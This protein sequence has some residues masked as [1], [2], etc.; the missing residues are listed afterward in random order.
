MKRN[1]VLIA[2]AIVGIL[3]S[4]A[5]TTTATS[6][7][8]LGDIDYYNT[9]NNFIVNETIPGNVAL[10][11]VYSEMKESS[12]TDEKIWYNDNVTTYRFTTN[13]TYVEWWF[14][15]GIKYFV[16][17]DIIT[18]KLYSVGVNYTDIDIPE[19]PYTERQ[20]Q[21][22]ENYTLI[23][24]NYNLT[25]AT[26]TNITT[27][28][29]ELNDTYGV[30]MQ[31]L[32]ITLTEKQNLSENLTDVRTA[33]TK[34]DNDYN[35]TYALWESAVDNVTHFQTEYEGKAFDYKELKKD[36]DDLSGAAPWYVIIAIIGTFLATWIY[37][38][39]K[40]IF[41]TT[42]EST[43]EI[44]T[45]Y[46]KVHSAIDKH[47]LSRLKGDAKTGNEGGIEEITDLKDGPAKGIPQNETKN[48]PIEKTAQDD[49]LEI[50]HKKIDENTRALTKQFTDG[51]K[52]IN[53]KIDKIISEKATN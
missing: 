39:R 28:F 9:Q 33:F 5:V 40:N 50:V 32:N 25:N 1:Y 38:R 13:K 45:G 6:I 37:I 19:N 48:E 42:Q 35:D 41:E 23:M 52:D 43:D 10:I 17:Q 30:I 18:N 21:L 53:E 7:T 31:Q 46:G 12:L 16:Y 2:L 15:P 51:L 49:I 4:C 22:V 14:T 11:F 27:Q 8:N 26:L 47:I 36:H 3:G 24:N 44:T 34:L 20:R 29:N